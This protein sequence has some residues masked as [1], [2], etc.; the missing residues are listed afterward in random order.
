MLNT[1]K[2]KRMQIYFVSFGIKL[3]NVKFENY[4]KN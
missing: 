4:E 3:I 2:E 1:N